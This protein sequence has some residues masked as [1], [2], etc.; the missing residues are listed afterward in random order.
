M[1]LCFSGCL[2]VDFS[3]FGDFSRF[4]GFLLL[5]RVALAFLVVAMMFMGHSL[6][7]AFPL[8]F[9]IQR[10]IGNRVFLLRFVEFSSRALFFACEIQ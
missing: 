3:Y 8:Y 5:F 9:L 10:L 6:V 1:N 7:S 2:G 4:E